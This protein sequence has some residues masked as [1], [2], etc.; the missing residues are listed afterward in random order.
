MNVGFIKTNIPPLI[1]V[2][3][4][5]LLSSNFNRRYDY[6]P[7]PPSLSLILLV[8]FLEVD[9]VLLSLFP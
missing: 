8:E 1:S 2:V 9:Q 7:I 3:I 6:L 5:L 4:S